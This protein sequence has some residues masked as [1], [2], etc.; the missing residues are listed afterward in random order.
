MRNNPQDFSH[1]KIYKIVFFISFQFPL[2]KMARL[3]GLFYGIPLIL[4]GD[5]KE[6]SIAFHILTGEPH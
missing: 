4:K 6:I 5:S 3:H 1:D 2:L